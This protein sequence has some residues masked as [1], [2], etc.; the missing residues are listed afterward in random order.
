M[1]LGT[2]S[3][4][5]LG[6]GLEL[7][8]MLEDLRSIDETPINRQKD[9]KLLL[10]SQ[11]RTLDTLNASL[12]GIRASART[13]SL[14]S[15]F[16]NRKVT[17]GKDDVATATASSG[18]AEG[19]HTLD[20]HS[21]AKKSTWQS[22]GGFSDPSATFYDHPKTGLLSGDSIALEEA[23]TVHLTFGSREEKISVEIPAGATLNEV[24]EAINNAPG[25]LDENGK[26]LMRASLATAPSGDSYL[27]IQPADPD[28]TVH[29]NII[30]EGTEEGP[31]LSF[32]K[33]DITFSFKMGDENE[34]LYVRIPPGSSYQGMV[35][36]INE[37]AEKHG[38]DASIINDGSSKDPYRFTLT[39]RETG[40]ANRIFLSP[41]FAGIMDEVQGGDEESLN[42]KFTVNGIHYQRNSDKGLEDVIAGL[43]LN[44][45]SEGKTTISIRPDHDEVK[46]DIVKMMED[47]VKFSEDLARHMVREPENEDEGLLYNVSSVKNVQSQLRNL[48]S[49]PMGKGSVTT[50]A[51]LGLTMDSSGR[52]HFD[53]KKLDEVMASDPEG[54]RSFFIGDKEKSQQG[55]GDMFNERLT[56]MTS[57]TGPLSLEKN[58][59]EQRAERMEKSIESAT[60][61]LD[62][63]Y[64]IMTHEFIRLDKAI[65]SLNSQADFM[66]SMFDSFTNAQNNNRK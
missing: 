5:G 49:Q 64:E 47:L 42:A 41:N 57:D 62:R 59:M 19:S 55:F 20:V 27:Y 43:T 18:I 34:P 44:L 17:S 16:L 24:A 11:A 14:E 22:S 29:Q 45:E 25:N 7:Q 33:S 65:S 54:V 48:V 50:L 58:T 2:I 46:D 8:Q 63:K 53:E 51:D 36:A 52:M 56:Q 13:L 31:D 3:T 60:A 9:Q 15:S 40:E 37:Q 39:A 30:I 35:N 32:L 12:M 61:R 28:E 21:L 6:S 10:K 38:M 4:V 1:A 23:T 66:K 26:P